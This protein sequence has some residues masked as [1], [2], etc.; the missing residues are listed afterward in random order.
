MS[1]GAELR[2]SRERKEASREGRKERGKGIRRE[3]RWEGPRESCG[4][5]SLPSAGYAGPEWVQGAEGKQRFTTS[6]VRIAF[7]S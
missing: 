2:A 6:G 5:G 3:E 4:P 7:C 1:V